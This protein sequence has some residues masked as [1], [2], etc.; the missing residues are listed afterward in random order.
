MKQTPLKR[1]TPLRAKKPLQ[2]KSEIKRGKPLRQVSKR[3][4]AV[5]DYRRSLREKLVQ[6]RGNICELRCSPDCR[7]RCE[8][9]HEPLKQAAKR[10]EI[11]DDRRVLLSC[12]V[13]N[14]WVEDNPAKARALGLT[15]S[16]FKPQDR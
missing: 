1:K 3:R 9:L 2:A 14:G 12:D 7:R 11:G 5:M 10:F 15:E 6:E 4:R 8:G 16:R 13:C